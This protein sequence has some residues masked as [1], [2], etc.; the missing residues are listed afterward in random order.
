MGTNGQADGYDKG[1]ITRLC[2]RAYYVTAKYNSQSENDTVKICC[3]VTILF[4]HILF[5]F[6]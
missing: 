5:L 4:H 3:P 1:Y 2:E 6:S